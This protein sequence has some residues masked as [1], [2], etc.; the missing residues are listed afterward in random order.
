MR[1]TQGNGV[2]SALAVDP[3]MI[4][5]DHRNYRELMTQFGRGLEKGA[6]CKTALKNSKSIADRTMCRFKTVAIGRL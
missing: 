6:W 1:Y 3:V 5:Q 2:L 4:L